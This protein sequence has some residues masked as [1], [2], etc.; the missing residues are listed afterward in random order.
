MSSHIAR[1]V[2]MIL[3]C[4]GNHAALAD[5]AF[6]L[7]PKEPVTLKGNLAP[8]KDASWTVVVKGA[9]QGRLAVVKG[10]AG[11]VADIYDAQNITANEGVSEEDWFPITS[12]P[13]TITLTNV[14]ALGAKA[15]GHNVAYEVRFEAK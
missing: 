8:R 10:Q 1:L 2:A 12:G 7:S 15:A 13:Y 14:T 9:R 6:V 5:P 4:L 11:V 3:L